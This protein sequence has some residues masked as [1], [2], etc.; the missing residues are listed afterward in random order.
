MRTI[1][2]NVSRIT[3]AAVSDVNGDGMEDVILTFANGTA[4]A[5]CGTSFR[6][7]WTYLGSA[8]TSLRSVRAVQ[9][10]DF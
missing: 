7:L 8:D 2:S 10:F 9:S 6:V 1:L 5:L 4:S 3:G